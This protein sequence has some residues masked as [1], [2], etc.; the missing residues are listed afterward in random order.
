MVDFPAMELIPKV[1]WVHR[2]PIF[3]TLR[4][5][6]HVMTENSLGLVLVDLK[7]F[8]G[9]IYGWWRIADYTSSKSIKHM[10]IWQTAGLLPAT[11]VT[12]GYF[13]QGGCSKPFFK[14]LKK[15]FQWE[16]DASMAHT[17]HRTTTGHGLRDEHTKQGMPCG[18]HWDGLFCRG[19]SLLAMPSYSLEPKC[20]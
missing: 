15:D 1:I 19:R 13:N 11:V 18:D 5:R 12:N 10:W 7:P 17:Q 14:Q 4:Q 9:C 20:Q 16:W 3:W 6:C 2:C 8:L